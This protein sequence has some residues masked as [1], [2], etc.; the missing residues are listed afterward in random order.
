VSTVRGLKVD[1]ATGDLAHDG[2][3]LQLVEDIDAIAQSL[4]TRLGFFRGEWFLDEAFGLPYFQT[5]LGVKVPQSVILEE[6]RKVI[7][8]T[9]GVRTLDK[10]E[11]QRIGTTRA[12]TLRFSVSTDLGDL[13]LAVPVGA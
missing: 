11:L 1:P 10:L 6:F 4:R 7:V 12:F 5:I 8:A 3:R 2:K 9:R 13:V